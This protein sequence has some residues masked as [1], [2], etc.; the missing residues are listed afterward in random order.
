MHHLAAFSDPRPNTDYS[1]G[2]PVS[3]ITLTFTRKTRSAEC[4]T[5]NTNKY[6]D[7]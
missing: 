4:V 2:K 5:N 7:I 1:L 3:Y 6:V